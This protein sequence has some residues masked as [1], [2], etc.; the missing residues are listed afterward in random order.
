M[1]GQILRLKATPTLGG[2]IEG[3]LGDLD[4]PAS[5]GTLLEAWSGDL[6]LLGSGSD[7]VGEREG[8]GSDKV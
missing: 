8:G 5:G 3:V 6:Q 2:L 7:Y 4:D 1:S